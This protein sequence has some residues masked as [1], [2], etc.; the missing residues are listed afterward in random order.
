MN[1]II[2][3]RLIIRSFCDVDAEGL[4]DYLAEPGAPCFADEKLNSL[5]DAQREIKKRSQDPTQLAICLKGSDYIIGNLFA[6]NKN[7]PDSETWCIG[8]HLNKKYGGNGYATEAAKAF[9]EYLFNQKHARRIYAYVADYNQPSQNL[10][11]RLGM[12]TEGC[13][14]EHVEFMHS[15]GHRQFEDTL[16]FAVLRKE[17]SV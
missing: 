15:D 2:T 6:D 1:I 17:W 8:W 3:N 10:C 7:E 14:K 13:F 4:F 16:V 9:I 12:R 11:K 5:I